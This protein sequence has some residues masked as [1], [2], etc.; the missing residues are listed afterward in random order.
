MSLAIDG[1]QDAPD[2]IVPEQP[3]RRNFGQRV[4]DV[5]QKLTTR[6]GLLGDYNYGELCCTALLGY[7]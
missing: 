3:R 7:T 4:T 5:K 1:P 6:Q 2:T